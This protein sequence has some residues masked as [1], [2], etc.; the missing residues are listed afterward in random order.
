[1]LITIIAFII[2]MG[3]IV[4]IHE[5]GHFQVARWCGVRVLRFSIGFGKPLWRKEIG[6]DKTELVLAAIPLGGYVKMLDEYELKAELARAQ[7][8]QETLNKT[9]PKSYSEVELKRA[10]NRQSIYKRIAIVL[11]G[12][13]ANMLLAIIVYWFLFMQGVVGM[14][15]IVGQV[16]EASLAAQANF[17]SGDVIK[18]IDGEAVKTWFDARWLLFNASLEKNTVEVEVVNDKNEPIAHKLHFDGIS[19]DADVD[20]LERIGLEMFFPDFPAIIDQVLPGGVA[21]Q[22]GIKGNDRILSINNMSVAHWRDAVDIIKVNANKPLLLKIERQQEIIEVNI[23]PKGVK[24]N[25]KIIGKIGITVKVEQEK[26][27]QLKIEQRFPPLVS[28]SMAVNKTWETSKFS[29]KMLW[30]MIVGKTS[31]KGISGPVTIASYAG[32]SANLGIKAFLGFLALISISI[33]VL[34]LLP[35]PILDG[36]HLMYYMAEIIKGSPVSEQT[37][38]LGQKIGLGLLG[39]LMTVAIFNDINRIIG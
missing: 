32:Q 18:K 14:R 36:A 7:N 10:F 25:N 38:L 35:I 37:M 17:M 23:T 19:E 20:I 16:Q 29:L 12:P 24:E 33:G 4:T 11:A 30:Y 26:I 6:K 8:Q 1:M 28:L 2:T 27:E 22:S 15:P 5:Y 9:L 13:M 21:K 31:W 3:L 39:L 34:N